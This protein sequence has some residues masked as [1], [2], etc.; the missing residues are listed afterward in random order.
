[1]GTQAGSRRRDDEPS[2]FEC[3]VCDTQTS[4]N[5]IEYDALGYAVCPVCTYTHGP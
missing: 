4:R 3:P 1:M 2:T 5:V